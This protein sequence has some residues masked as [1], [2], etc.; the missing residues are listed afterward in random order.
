MGRK[1]WNDPKDW[2]LLLRVV[3]CRLC[4]G[5]FVILADVL[6]P[7]HQPEGAMI[8]PIDDN[9]HW[10][11]P[12][13]RWDSIHF[14]KIVYRGYEFDL[15]F[16]FFPLW[17]YVL[18]LLLP[19]A[20]EAYL[21]LLSFTANLILLVW[22]TFILRKIL[23]RAL[24]L[25]LSTERSNLL[26]SCAIFAH[27]LS[28]ASIFFS[29]IYSE[30]LYCVLK[31]SAILCLSQNKVLLSSLFIALASCT[32][33]TGS[34]N[35]VFVITYMIYPIV[36]KA[37]A[38]ISLRPFSTMSMSLWLSLCLLVLSATLPPL[39]WS[40]A[41]Y[42]TMCNSSS[43]TSPSY[44]HSISPLSFYSHMQEM[45]WGV[46]LL[47]FY[48]L[49]Q[50]PNI[51]IGVLPCAL[52]LRFA[53]RCVSQQMASPPTNDNNTRLAMSLC[54]DLIVHV[55]VVLLFAHVNIAM[56]VLAASSPLMALSIA[57]AY[58]TEP[59]SRSD[60]MWRLIARVVWIGYLVVGTALH[61]N[62]FPWT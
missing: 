12:F 6:L 37:Y 2:Q 13:L 31:W 24:K 49:R 27:I 9:F 53:A 22:S 16:A 3:V 4:F 55:V 58:L 59:R 28:P 51:M 54:A 25:Q 43:S 48:Q 15:Q 32:R 8:W 20:D 29:S 46:G 35:I 57:D 17:P 62:F 23:L 10:W 38:Q 36:T 61:A 1:W 39:L 50:L 11:K 56:R 30:S 40:S 34:L 44:C 26:L 33:S 14:A 21:T 60:R 19:I 5:L 7:D 47:R 45:H 41:G 18:K 42:Y 52:A